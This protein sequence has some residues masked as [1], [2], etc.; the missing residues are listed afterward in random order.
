MGGAKRAERQRRQRAVQAAKQA[1]KSGAAKRAARPAGKSGAA[2][3]AT[4]PAGKSGAAGRSGRFDGNRRRIAVAL[5][6]VVLLVAAVA[7]GVLWQRSRSGP[8][9]AQ[10]VPVTAEYPVALTDGVVVAG[11]DSAGVTVEIYEDFLC[12][13]CR[14]F[15]ERDAAAIE[16][17]LA[18]GTVRVRYHMVNILDNRSNPPGYSTDAANAALCA[19]DAGKFPGYHASL[20]GSQPREGGRGYTDDQLVQ[21][22]RDLDI[23]GAGAPARMTPTSTPRSRRPRPRRPCEAA[24]GSAHQPSSS[25]AS[26]STSARPPGSPTPLP[27]PANAL[28]LP[29]VTWASLDAC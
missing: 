23:T 25:T 12:P 11:K 17:A 20:F 5:V 21:L 7:A 1:G 26:S 2:K 16:N 14:E 8:D 19:A 10:A 24:A 18:A 29:D 4:P 22:G 15:E 27:Q 28:P 6:V 3:R 13:T 9:P